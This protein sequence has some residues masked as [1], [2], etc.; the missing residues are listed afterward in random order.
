MKSLIFMFGAFVALSTF[1]ACGK[2]S[3]NKVNNDSTTVVDSV[4]QDSLVKDS[5]KKDSLTKDSLKNITSKK[6]K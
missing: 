1:V 3:T 6:T 2:S 5:L 4:K